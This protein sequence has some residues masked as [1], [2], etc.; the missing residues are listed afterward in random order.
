MRKKKKSREQPEKKDA[1]SIGKNLLK[2][3]QISHH[4]MWRPDRSGTTYL[5]CKEKNY[6]PSSTSTENTLQEWKVKKFSD[7]EK[8]IDSL[9]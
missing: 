4:E 9:S 8:H 2:W 3:L 6:Q 5:K 1:L 7:E